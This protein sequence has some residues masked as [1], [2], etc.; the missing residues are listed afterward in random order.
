MSISVTK[1]LHWIFKSLVDIHG[2]A[3]LATKGVLLANIISLKFVCL[4]RDNITELNKDFIAI[5]KQGFL[6]RIIR[7]RVKN[8]LSL[9]LIAIVVKVIHLVLLVKTFLFTL[10]LIVHAMQIAH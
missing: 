3:E 10:H 1:D 5:V 6:I 9:Y 2:N 4:A 7:L 8:A